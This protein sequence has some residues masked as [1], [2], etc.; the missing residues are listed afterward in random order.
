MGTYSDISKG[1][2]ASAPAAP[3]ICTCLIDSI[4]L[5]YLFFSVDLT[6]NALDSVLTVKRE[7]QISTGSRCVCFHVKYT[8]VSLS[9]GS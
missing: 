1:A 3:P 8:F 4:K 2:G 5:R 6:L 7:S 9:F